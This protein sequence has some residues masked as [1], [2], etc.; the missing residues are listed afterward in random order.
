MAGESY[1]K[2]PAFVWYGT[3]YRHYIK[4][5][6]QLDKSYVR[7]EGDFTMKDE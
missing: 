4:I 1:K 3:L 6:P 7:S 2:H 5:M